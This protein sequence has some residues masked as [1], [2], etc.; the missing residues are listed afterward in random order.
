MK[1]HVIRTPFI[2]AG[3]TKDNLGCPA[4]F[5]VLP[6]T[7]D[8]INL[9]NSHPKTMTQS[10]S[11]AHKSRSAHQEADYTKTDKPSPGS[12]HQGK[13]FAKVSKS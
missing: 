3:Y 11:L 13:V 5:S 8:G 12:A 4:L 7:Y 2:W 10:H 6:L 1:D 9:L